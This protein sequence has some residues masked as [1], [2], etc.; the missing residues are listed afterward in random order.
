MR[1][2]GLE[3][4]QGAERIAPTRTCHGEYIRIIWEKCS[5]RVG[6]LETRRE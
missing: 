1:V 6:R 4:G 5:G 3:G 2:I